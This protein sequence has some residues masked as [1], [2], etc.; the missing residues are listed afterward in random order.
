MD[1]FQKFPDRLQ[2]LHFAFVVLLRAVQRA[3][4]YFRDYHFNTGEAE[5]DKKTQTLIHRLLDS[6]SLDSCQSVFGG[7][8]EGDMFLDDGDRDTPYSKLELKEIIINSRINFNNFS[9]TEIS[10]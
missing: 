1:Q 5:E 4:D 9:E 8:N 3:K 2:N 7:F 6:S 10:C